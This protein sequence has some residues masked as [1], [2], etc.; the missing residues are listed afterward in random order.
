MKYIQLILLVLMGLNLYAQSDSAYKKHPNDLFYTQMNLVAQ[1]VKNKKPIKIAV[2][3]VGFRLTHKS[4]QP[5][6][7]VNEK[8]IPGNGLDDDKNGFI[9]D[10]IGW[11]VGDAD[12]DVSV[13]EGLADNFYHGTYIM[14]IIAETL[15]RVLGAAATVHVQLVPVKIVSDNDQVFALRDAY[16]GFAYARTIGADLIC[17][18][19]SGGTIVEADRK[20]VAELVQEGRI[21]VGAAGNL[22]SEK[23]LPPGSMQGVIAVTA[24]DS[25][26][27]KHDRANFGVR[28]DIAAPGKDVYGAHPIADNAFIR[29]SGTSPA[30]AFIT[31]LMAVLKL[32][33]TEASPA[34][35]LEALQNTATPI[36]TYNRSFTGKL[37]A[38]LPNLGKAVA[39]L[40]DAAQRSAFF[41]STRTRGWLLPSGRQKN[42]HWKISPIGGYKGLRIWPAYTSDKGRLN[43][44]SGQTIVYAGP[45]ASLNELMLLEGQSFSVDYFP[46]NRSSKMQRFKYVIEPID[47]STLYCRDKQTIQV[48]DSG[49]LDDGSAAFPYSN[50]CVCM[51]QLSAPAGKRIQIQFTELETEPNRDQIFF[52]DGVATH[53]DYLFASIS[54]NRLP[55]SFESSSSNVLIWFLS[56]KVNVYAGWKLKYK[57]IE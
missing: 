3:D 48:S 57:V 29:E 20:T 38:G 18:A 49:W 50:N 32:K 6:I 40:S 9:D 27:T 47:S 24:I 2:L 51:W 25:F 12:G 46:N 53:P 45:V 5:F 10:R 39:Y 41:D 22:S 44:Q 19:W 31:A 16:K 13:P 15:V 42:D 17:C 55:P 4:I 23:V 43:I 35:L 30:T 14:S 1:S 8:E 11:D 21:L 52:Y 54:G 28:V 36:D 37:G 7:K 34:E 33:F 56:D 26:F